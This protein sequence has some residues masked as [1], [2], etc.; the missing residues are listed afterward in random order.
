MESVWDAVV[1]QE[2]P[3]AVLRRT[4][5][6]PVH[7]YLFVG[8]PGCGS[9]TAARAT[10]A[11][12]LSG[13]DDPADRICDVVMRGL[14][15]DVHEI[16]RDGASLLK[17]QAEDVIRLASTTGTESARK[18]LIIHDVHTMDAS[19]A[20]RLLKT[21]EEPPAGVVLILLADQLVPSLTTIASR[22]VIIRFA[23][24]QHETVVA[25]LVGEGADAVAAESAAR[26][27]LGDLDR[28]RL[29]V[30]DDGLA[31]R[32]EAFAA[33][34]RRLDGTGATVAT[35]TA[36]LTELVEASLEA[37]KERQAGEITAKDA[38]LAAAG[39]RKGGKK[40]LEDRH[41]R[42]L[43]QHRAD[44]W[45]V[46]LSQIAATYR[47]E[48][49]DRPEIHDLEAY[50]RA[51]SR[52]HEAIGRLGLNVNEGLMLRNLLWSLPALTADE[53]LHGANR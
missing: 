51:V 34:P 18:I 44:E 28:A 10:A 42:E 5:A 47:D 26:F 19:A 11:E 22:C 12:I 29:L 45:R 30:R 41:R 53:L 16:R 31:R 39:T 6:S 8:P 14:H 46:G 32:Y 40:A 33:V 20:A 48:L 2:R 3:V 23:P 4:L 7:A 37:L 50:A 25:T 49:V 38:E 36:E 15:A 35:V 17:A 9:T 13:V 43:R 21:V 24:L 1:G 52:V 27:A